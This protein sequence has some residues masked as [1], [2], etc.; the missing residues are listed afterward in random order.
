[1]KSAIYI[2][3]GVTQVV[4]T[5]ENEWERNSLKMIKNAGD[6]QIFEGGFYECQGGWYRHSR[7]TGYNESSLI[8]RVNKAKPETVC[9][10]NGQ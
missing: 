1:M 2:E 6:L 9:T 3:E 8:L 7:G 4:L 10:E 5:P